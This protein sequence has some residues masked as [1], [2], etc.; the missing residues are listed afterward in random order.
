[1][2][3]ARHRRLALVVTACAAAFAV[4]LIAV[5][6]ATA[7]PLA[8]GA[9]ELT[10]PANADATAPD[11]RL[12]SVSCG[13]VGSCAAVGTYTSASGPIKAM[14]A[15]QVNGIWSAATGLSL[16]GNADATDP[17]PD[18]SWVSCG[19]AGSCVAVGRYIDAAGHTRVLVAPQSSGSWSQA[20]ELQ[21]PGDAATD[22]DARLATVS[23]PS[24]G[25]CATVG[26]YSVSGGVKA[27]V[28]SRSNG[29]WSS[30]TAL[31]PPGDADTTTPSFALGSV[32]CGAA[33]SC[34]T[35]GYYRDT[36]GANRAMVASL[37]GGTWSSATQVALPGNAASSGQ[38]AA[39]YSVACRAAGSC[40]AVGYYTDS[41]GGYRGMTLTQTN[42]SWSAATEIPAPADVITPPFTQL[43]S[44]DCGAVGSCATAGSYTDVT[45]HSRAL[46]ASQSNGIWSGAVELAPPDPH[47]ANPERV[48]SAVAC[49]GPGSCA[50]VGF[51]IDGAGGQEPMAA[52]QSA[53]EWS[54]ASAVA[55]PPNAAASPT[56]GSSLDAIACPAAASCS[57]V[58]AYRDTS[59]AQRPMVAY[60]RAALAIST[61]DLSPA[62][63]GAPY[64]AQLAA[65][66]G[67][68]TQTWRIDS[69]SLPA[70]LALEPQTG[71]ISGTPTEA[72]TSLFTVKAS[73]EG[74]PV[75]NATRALSIVVGPPATATAPPPTAAPRRPLVA[76]KAT[77]LIAA[78]GAVRV[79]LTCRHAHCSGTIQLRSAA[80]RRAVALA[81]GRYTIARGS[82][83]TLTIRLTKAGKKA[84]KRARTR[85]MRARLVVVVTG[86]ATTSTSVVVGQALPRRGG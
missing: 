12:A 3:G 58:G 37:A 50:A 43:L 44:I 60:A 77:K 30:A 71:R 57:A 64:A 69:G 78:K 13:A 18:L 35:G 5:T 15:S 68:G 83:R 41:A 32:A 9:T 40:S 51:Y 27:M 70:G 8:W 52:S 61:S 19:A 23:C 20:A 26:S 66:G 59:G 6:P 80:K 74:P 46:V 34:S 11:A 16:P 55:L 22:P 29:T 47:T 62:Q 49:G 38:D 2:R 63:V 48:L 36:A 53:G 65:S 10:L 24:A 25:S 85:P 76:V 73:D 21:L 45:N 81:Q 84:L 82:T 39:V 33:G 7:A 86:A 4:C 14:V 1:M 17:A 72:G 42:G 56:Q 75:Q 31:T 54:G 28:A 67:S 79:T